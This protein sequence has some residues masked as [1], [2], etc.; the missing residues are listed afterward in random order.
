MFYQYRRNKKGLLIILLYQQLTEIYI[1][2][3]FKTRQR[4]LRTK[5]RIYGRQILLSIQN[6]DLAF[7]GIM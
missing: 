2:Q 4:T 7:H 5:N 6:I 1:D 3:L